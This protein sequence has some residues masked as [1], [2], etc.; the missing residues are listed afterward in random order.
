MRK[1]L[2]SIVLLLHVQFSTAQTNEQDSIGGISW[3]AGGDLQL[4]GEM[5][6]DQVSY[7]GRVNLNGG[8]FV[9]TNVL[10]GLEAGYTI[11]PLSR[12]TELVPMSRY[13]YFFEGDRHALYAGLKG[14]Y[15]WGVDE[16]SFSGTTKGRYA[17]IWGARAGYLSRFNKHVA[18]DIF[19]F[20]NERYS[21]SERQDGFYTNPSMTSAFGIGIGFQVFL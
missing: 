12:Y 15:A 8:Y 4:N 2:L 14:G 1:L 5:V 19:A 21:A 16:S 10:I 7:Y 3:L 6:L 11:S 13:Y 20:Y 17:W 18:L 9:H